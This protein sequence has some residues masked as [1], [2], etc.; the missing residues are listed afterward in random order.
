MTSEQVTKWLFWVCWQCWFPIWLV[1]L[2]T[3]L[4]F[5]RSNCLNLTCNWK[6][7]IIGKKHLM[8][9]RNNLSCNI[10]PC[11]VLFTTKWP[12]Y[13]MYLYNV[14]NSTCSWKLCTTEPTWIPTGW[15]PNTESAQGGLGKLMM[16]AS[17]FGTWFPSGVN[18]E[19]I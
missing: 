10:S 7:M 11:H 16:A 19:A 15:T 12:H 1:E 17:V 4:H 14:L 5:A 8:R 2:M 18:N 9:L 13:L 6:Q 3:I